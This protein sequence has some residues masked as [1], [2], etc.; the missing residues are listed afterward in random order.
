MKKEIGSEF[1][2]IPIT[3]YKNSFFD[4][5][6]WFVS[7]RSALRAI[8]RHIVNKQKSSKFRIAMPSYLCESMIE[9]LDKESIDYLFYSV[10][11]KNGKIEYDY[12]N[13][14]TCDAI[15][16]MDY[17]GYDVPLCDNLALANKI[18]IRDIT[19]SV[20]TKK[21]NDADYYFGSLRKWAGFIGGGFAFKKSGKINGTYE[22]DEQYINLRRLAFN[23]KEKYIYGFINDKLFLNIFAEADQK[24]EGC[25][26][27]NTTCSDIEAASR[28]DIELIK[29]KRREN[30]KILIDGLREH[31]LF[32]QLG[33]KDCPLFVPILVENRDI[34]R[35]FL[36]KE[37]IYCPIHWPKPFKEKSDSDFLYEHELSLVCD[38]RYSVD[39]MKRIVK[40]IKYFL[41]SERNA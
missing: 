28:L 26:L 16:V 11:F 21:Y 4:D 13:A 33:K 17:F 5:V 40:T 38:Q 8:V 36:I 10:A 15:V 32:S 31:C 3:D 34:L 7:G 22:V 35:D 14:E 23:L 27:V 19:H 20:F 18:I 30:A 39:D 9:P 12:K 41:E 1:W 37:G 6:T 2:N 24:L 25:C 29:N